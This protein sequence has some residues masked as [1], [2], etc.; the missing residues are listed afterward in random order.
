VNSTYGANKVRLPRKEGA[1]D[2]YAARDDVLLWAEILQAPIKE[3]V[4]GL[5]RESM[6]AL[7]PDASSGPIVC[8]VV[9]VALW[10]DSRGRGQ[11]SAATPAPP[12][13]VASTMRFREWLEVGSEGS[14]RLEKSPGGCEFYFASP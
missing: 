10:T 3:W 13:A 12:R 9:G 2:A 7:P 1:R 5:R 11:R 4:L 8:Q 14:A 6:V